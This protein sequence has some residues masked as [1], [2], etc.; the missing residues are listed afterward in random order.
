[1][2]ITFC[3]LIIAESDEMDLLCSFFDKAQPLSINF[4]MLDGLTHA[5][6][7]KF[8]KISC[9]PSLQEIS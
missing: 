6:L 7:L 3:S 4:S 1:P 5:G 9:N 2:F 8:L